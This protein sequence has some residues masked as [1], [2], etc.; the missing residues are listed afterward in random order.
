M[1]I[2]LLDQI[3]FDRCLEFQHALLERIA[4]RDDGQITLLLC[5][6]PRIITVGRR[7]S[8]ADIASDN[9]LIQTGEIPIRWVNRGGGCMLHCPGQLAVY[10]LVPLKWR[11]FTLGEY[12]QR[13]LSGIVECLIESGIRAEV[14]P[15]GHEV[16]GRTGKLAALG[17]AVRH[18]VTYYGAY[19]N[20][21][22]PLGL[23]RLITGGNSENSPG[24]R[25][26]QTRVSSLVSERRGS[27]KMPAVRAILVQKLAAA[28]GCDR[29][30][31]YTGHPLL[32]KQRTA[33]SI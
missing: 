31:L 16:W 27:I 17:V 12:L 3:D 6:H 11:S 25:W 7:G 19:L 32:K 8:P 1:E 30:H 21:S 24:D 4:S 26:D 9:R 20:V 5:E 2:Y 15:G 23:F 14:P 29:F 28:F 22:P 33:G 18:G 10:P 13:L